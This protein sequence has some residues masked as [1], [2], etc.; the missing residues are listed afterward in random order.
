MSFNIPSQP[1]ADALTAFGQQSGL[2][3]MLA[4]T[5]NADAVSQAVVG[6]YSLD[7]ALA[8]IL[9]STGLKA[10]Y[11]DKKTVSIRAAQTSPSD[12]G[13]STK[14]TGDSTSRNSGSSA[15]EGA[16]GD[17][18]E[19]ASAAIPEI[20]VEGSRSL[21]A[22]IRRTPDDI[23]PYVVLNHEAI[24]NSGAANIEDLLKTRLTMNYA[25]VSGNQ[26]LVAGQG[27]ESSIALRGLSS[28][29]TLILIDGRQ[30]GVR[31]IAGSGL[32]PDLNTIPLNAIERIE[33]LPTTASGIYGG[34]ATGGVIN[35]VL[36]HD[37][38]GIETALTYEN[39][40]QNGGSTRRADVTG[41]F[42]ANNGK[43]N[44]FVRGSYVSG[45]QLLFEDRHFVSDYISMRNSN[46][47]L[48]ATTPPLGETANVCSATV[49]SASVAICNKAPL[50]LTNGTP[51]GSSTTF[52]PVGYGGVSTDNG[53][54]LVS[55]AGKYNLNP[56]NNAQN[57]F[58]THTT[59]WSPPDVQ[60]VALTLRQ[61]ISPRLETFVDLSESVSRADFDSQTI[62]SS[63]A[64]PASA[65]GNPFKQGV[66]VTAPLL[67]ADETVSSRTSGWR[68]LA[69]AKL[70][71]SSSWSSEL[72]Y[73]FDRADF[74][75]TF[76]ATLFSP[77]A[78]T[79]IA[80]G[81]V[82][83]FSSSPNLSS[84]LVPSAAIS[85]THSL[86]ND[87]TL[88]V[89]GTLAQ[90][91]GGP[92][93][94][95]I[96]IEDRRERFSS[97]TQVTPEPTGNPTVSGYGPG[98][99]V[100]RSAYL[101]I[102]M[103]IASEAQNIPGV[104]LLELQAAGR[105]ESFH[106]DSASAYSVGAA[107]Q[108]SSTDRLHSLD[109]TVG[110]RF[111]PVSDVMLRASYGS[112]F[113]PPQMQQLIAPGAPL[114]LPN[115]FRLVDPRRGGQLLGTIQ[116]T[117]GGNP[118]LRPEVSESVSAGIVLTPTVLQGFRASLDWTRISKEDNIV[119]AGLVQSTINNELETPGVITRAPVPPGDPY[120]VGPITAINGALFNA[121]HA[122]IVSYD[123]SLEY[124]RDIG[125]LGTWSLM[126]AATRLEHNAVQLSAL[127]IPQEEAGTEFSPT[128]NA[129]ATLSWS[130]GRLGLAWTTQFLDWYWVNTD[131]S[132]NTA[133]GSAT[134]P[135]AVYHD[136]TA[137]YRTGA[138]SGSAAGWLSN[139]EIR[140]GVKDI[141]NTKPRF[142]ATSFGAYDPWGNPRM[143]TYFLSVSES[144]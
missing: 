69:G 44:V 70:E 55:N 58:G 137:K 76:P 35:V 30:P 96:L 68:V 125:M 104:R 6:K 67:G 134:V 19:T 4:A 62:T 34:G 102:R 143:A 7:E 63:F 41:G 47:P 115:F 65:P 127:A 16:Q 29:Q 114:T 42:S 109:P 45:T 135:S 15:S 46:S 118:N 139:L 111:K 32:Q 52:V 133:Q 144:F 106:L 140:C 64:I 103:P 99:E 100:D 72:D 86:Q 81:T 91:A 3:I 128:W 90:L 33:I 66:Y 113:V 73:S 31:E 77:S 108:P 57:Q 26:T 28:E 11:L 8:K 61:S 98:D 40:I 119:G 80:K 75:Q 5:V 132:L 49:L 130:K 138:P 71:L 136:L 105:Y 38:S 53:A 9:A 25:P 43:S 59:L 36:R 24:Q 14:K 101:E 121:A 60:S 56:P 112:G 13:P 95:S 18:S 21:D 48:P 97:Y 107:F 123:L 131:H 74:R 85:P 120:S 83:A 89:A 87:V 23:Q 141:F 110:L 129:N 17:I 117:V 37:Y 2:T 22:D 54:A 79:S 142:L 1:V 126:G 20:L 88:H 12:S 39:T 51:L 116:Y 124:S 92:L 27:N 50:V 84:Y 10:E 82:N 122:R 93:A 94:A 78:A